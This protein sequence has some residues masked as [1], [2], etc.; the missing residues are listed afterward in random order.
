MVIQA[1]FEEYADDIRVR[2]SEV[3]DEGGPS[4]SGNTDNCIEVRGAY[5]RAGFI[6][7]VVPAM[8]KSDTIKAEGDALTAGCESVGNAVVAEGAS[9]FPTTFC[10]QV[11]RIS[12][13]INGVDF[14]E[15]TD[16]S[17]LLR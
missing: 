16:E 8:V 6:S 15:R 5:V 12:V 3:I 4:A 9:N 1:A 7:C 11:H 2:F 17:I 10:K 14:E 13:A